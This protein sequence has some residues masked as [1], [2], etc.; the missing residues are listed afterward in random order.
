[1]LTE[2]LCGV[3][4]PP[5]VVATTRVQGRGL[6]PATAIAGASLVGVSAAYGCRF[7][8]LR[9]SFLQLLLADVQ[10]QDM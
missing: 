5:G 3:L 8:S 10:L 2:S 4:P 6:S 9:P 1:M 7:Q